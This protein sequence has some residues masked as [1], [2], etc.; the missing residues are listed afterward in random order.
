MQTTTKQRLRG[1]ARLLLEHLRRAG[2][3]HRDDLL[4][5][6]RGSLLPQCGGKGAV[7]WAGRLGKDGPGFDPEGEKLVRVTELLDAAYGR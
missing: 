2:C 5:N 6:E 1:P 7:A 4:R 3:R